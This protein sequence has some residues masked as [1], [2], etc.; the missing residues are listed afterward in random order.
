MGTGVPLLSL[1]TFTFTFTKTV[2]MFLCSGMWHCEDGDISLHRNDD[3]ILSRCRSHI[4]E[5]NIRHCSAMTTERLT[6]ASSVVIF[7]TLGM[8]AAQES[9]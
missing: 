3:K 1:Y 7:E 8:S 2:K 6:N 4:P 9:A 5:N